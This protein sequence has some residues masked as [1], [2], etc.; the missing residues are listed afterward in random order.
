MGW[1]RRLVLSAIGTLAAAVSPASADEVEE[2]TIYGNSYGEG[3]YGGT[4][5]EC[6]IATAATSSNEPQVRELRRFRDEFLKQS[7][8]GRLCVRLYYRISPPIARWI[9]RSERR[10]RVI[11]GMLVVPAASITKHL[12]NRTET[13]E[14]E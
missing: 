10:K 3:G 7:A 6:F 1:S 5:S 11:R 2:E 14:N 13:T 8:P 9:S 4:A 12:P